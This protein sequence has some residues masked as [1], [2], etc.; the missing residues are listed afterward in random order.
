MV[1]KTAE[2]EIYKTENRQGQKY[3]WVRMKEVGFQY[4]S[5]SFREASVRSKKQS[6]TWT[7]DYSKRSDFD[8]SAGYWYVVKH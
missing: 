7:L 6:M 4:S 2:S 5:F 8:D 3:I 1:P